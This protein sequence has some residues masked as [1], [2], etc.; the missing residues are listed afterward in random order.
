MPDFQARHGEQEA[1][2]DAVLNQE[3]TLEEIDTDPF[4]F[5]AR[6]KPTRK[7]TK[8]ATNMVS[9]VTGRPASHAIRN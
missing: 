7:S 1:W 2:K 5:A 3:I 6:G 8:E 4:N 9:G